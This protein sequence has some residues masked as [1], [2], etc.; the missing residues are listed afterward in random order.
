[1][2][3]MEDGTHRAQ[4]FDDTSHRTAAQRIVAVE[5]RRQR[6]PGE[7]A[8]HQPEA[9]AGVAAVED[10]RP[11]AASASAPPRDDPVADRRAVALDPIDGRA[12]RR[13]DPGRR[14]DVRAVAGAR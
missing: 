6:Q 3:A 4:W 8:A 7:H 5:D 1:M 9:R 11:G 14:A 12:E 2:P 10:R 13:H